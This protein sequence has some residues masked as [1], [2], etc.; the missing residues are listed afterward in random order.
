MA[1]KFIVH[2]GTIVKAEGYLA[3]KWGL[4]GNLPVLHPYKNSAPIV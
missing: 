1:Q 4:E 2:N 3:W